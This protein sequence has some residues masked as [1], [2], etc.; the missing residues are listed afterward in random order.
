MN[1][2]DHMS[3]TKL[4]QSIGEDV[5]NNEDA[6]NIKKEVLLALNNNAWFQELTE[7]QKKHYLKGNTAFF[8][9]QDEIVEFSGGNVSEFRY[10]YRFLSNN[11]HSF[12]MGFYRMAD[13][14]R[15]RGI[16]TGIEIQY[17]GMCLE[18][19]GHYL[20]NAESEFIDLFEN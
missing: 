18:W 1:L 8:K 15:S 17:T 13:N 2:H 10:M 20:N 7:K 4:F 5:E 16:E 3:R 19:A 9:S 14:D 12:P 11:T 6:K